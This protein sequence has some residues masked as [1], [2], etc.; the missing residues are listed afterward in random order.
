M[1]KFECKLAE[2]LKTCESM[3]FLFIGSGIAQRYL[4]TESWEALL[5]HFAK[6][7]KPDVKFAYE[8]YQNKHLTD[9]E[10]PGAYFPKIAT[11]IENDFNEI[12]LTGEKWK[13]SRERNADFIGKV[14]PFKIAL[15]EH[16]E[17]KQLE[18]FYRKPMNEEIDLL[19]LMGEKSV[20]GI[21]TTNYDRL[22]EQL[23]PD[24]RVF[25]GQEELLFSN[26][27]NI[28][29]IYKIHGCCTNP[30]SLVIN[31]YDYEK[32]RQKN[33]YLA[34]KLLTIFVEH[35]IFFLGYSI[36]DRD[37]EETLQSIVECLPDEKLSVLKN[38][39]F[40]V[41]YDQK[42][43]TPDITPFEKV[44][45]GGHVG[46]T[47][48]TTADFAPIFNIILQNK[49]KYPAAVLRKL[50]EEIYRLVLTNDPKG[51]L[52]V[53]PF[54]DIYE[55]DDIE[56]YAGVGILGEVGVKGYNPISADDL[57]EDIVLDNLKDKGFDNL[58]FI[59]EKSLPRLIRDHNHS[60][61][62]Y[63]Y[64]G[65]YSF[66][67]PGVIKSEIKTSFDDFINASLKKSRNRNRYHSIQEIESVP[68]PQNLSA[69]AYLTQD[70]INLEDLGGFLEKLFK[71]KLEIL[72]DADVNLRSNVKRLIKIYDWLKYHK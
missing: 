9:G 53:R 3:P 5:R 24:F 67:L 57:F 49:S 58:A 69:I 29:E 40:F 4:K 63:K 62:I 28:A 55:S 16:F 21:I 50:K 64:L 19:K 52:F 35:P 10:K 8:L 36:N 15:A 54:N 59:V 22:L 61:P 38:R 1:N 44:F 43:Q 51:K 14:S 42:S 41:E 25:I 48:I 17:T 65:Q 66:P 20:A 56:I 70:E 60:I 31:E 68:F 27:Q 13:D 45:S 7:A 23:F 12:W 37:I 6:D 11:A 34:A 18:K 33:A 71:E 2:Q 32:F 30:A 26:P 39:L 47:K 72:K 46:M